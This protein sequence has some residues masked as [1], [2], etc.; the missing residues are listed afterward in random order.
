MNKTIAELTALKPINMQMK[1]FASPRVSG[2]SA[3]KKKSKEIN[4][5]T[6]DS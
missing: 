6:A 5:T 1:V 4:P 2:P 3:L